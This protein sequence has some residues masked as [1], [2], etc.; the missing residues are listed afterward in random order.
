MYTD[1]TQDLDA[2]IAAMHAAA[3]ALGAAKADELGLEDQRALVKRD[4]IKRLMQTTNELT[5]KPHSASSAETV[6]EGDEEYALHRAA[7]RV[8]AIESQVAWA[9]WE[10]A[11]ARVWAISKGGL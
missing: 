10:A 1:T 4:A 8:A 5:G 3:A 2:A 9:K 6:V 11:R 7:Q